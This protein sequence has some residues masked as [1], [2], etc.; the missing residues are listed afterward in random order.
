MVGYVG[1]VEFLRI[2]TA[3][4]GENIETVEYFVFN[5]ICNITWHS[6]TVVFIVFASSIS[7]VHCTPTGIFI[8]GFDHGP[9][10]PWG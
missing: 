2:F 5:T 6:N 4:P 8:Q 10:Q 3:H 1:T 7:F 9:W